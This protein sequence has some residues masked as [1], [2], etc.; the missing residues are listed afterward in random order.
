MTNKKKIKKKKS[1]KQKVNVKSTKS[2][3]IPMDKWFLGLG[4]ALFFLTL[5]AYYPSIHCDFTNWDDEV[6]VV[7]NTMMWKFDGSTISRIFSESVSSNY[8]PITML[9]LVLNYQFFGPEA[10]SFH[11]VNLIFHI[12]NVLL[13][14]YFFYFFS[15]KR[16]EVAFIV[17]FVFGIH[18]MHVESVTWISERKDVLYGFFF[19]LGMISYLRYSRRGEKLMYALTIL[20][21]VLSVLSKAM[22]VVFPLVLLL[23]DYWENK[24]LR[25][26]IVNKIPFFALSLFFG[27]LA[28]YIQQQGGAVGKIE[29]FT[30]LQRTMFAGYGFIMYIQK[31]FIPIGLT[32]FYPYPMLDANGYIPTFYYF[33]PILTA[34]ILA[35][36]VF[37]GRKNKW[38]AFGIGFYFFTVVLV[39]QFIS[40]GQVVMSERYTY[41]PYIGLGFILAGGFSYL[42]RNEQ[43]SQAVKY[44]AG[45][46]LGLVFAW[47]AYGTYERTKVW[48]NSE[49]LWTDVINK[50]NKSPQQVGL[51]YKNR[52]NYR[53]KNGRPKEA[54]EDLNLAVQFLP[55]DAGAL[56][57]LGNTYAG[58]G[59]SQQ[60]LE[61]YNRAI[62]ADP[63]FSSV[64]LNRAITYSILKNY[65]GAFGDYEKALS[66]GESRQNILTN[67]GYAFLEAGKIQEAIND[68]EE[69]LRY[70]PNEGSLYYYLS[71]CQFQLNN[72]P[73]AKELFN[74]SQALGFKG[75]APDYPARLQ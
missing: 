4:A 47:W 26:Q 14:F 3:F 58:M 53:G 34:I 28:F 11:V 18:P 52:G 64:Y 74:R 72:K 33:A 15:N 37:F 1:T 67:R 2:G 65:E 71:L 68:F 21:F 38:L 27:V 24:D 8:H 12:L 16:L 25:K 61:Q 36:G 48:Q 57:S 29:T 56:Q 45:L 43:I 23:I 30:F 50:Y 62:A 39:L 54:L 66:M 31:L 17:A 70:K 32:T 10:F 75:F 5:I 7:S 73:K 46:V 22:A 35:A 59:Q 9:S 19:F 49:T 20:F 40:V 13:V 41:L 6:Y 51:A 55:G 69:M 44:G 60:A 42:Y 63:A